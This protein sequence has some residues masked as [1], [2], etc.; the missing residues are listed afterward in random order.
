AVFSHRGALAV[1]FTVES[2]HPRASPLLPDAAPAARPVPRHTSHDATTAGRI[3]H[4]GHGRDLDTRAAHPG[5]GGRHTRDTAGRSVTVASARV[6]NGAVLVARVPAFRVVSP[7]SP[8]S[9]QLRQAT[10]LHRCSDM[11]VARYRQPSD[12]LLSRG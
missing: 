4:C 5:N 10:R 11:P 2:W 8:G 1:R 9:S 6:R 7:V 12:V 3:R